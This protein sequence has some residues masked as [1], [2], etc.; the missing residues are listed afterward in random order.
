MLA[1]YLSLDQTSKLK[2]LVISVPAFLVSMV[3]CTIDF[4]VLWQY[5]SWANQTLASISLWICTLYLLKI[6]KPIYYTFLPALFMTFVVITYILYAPIGLGLNI[7][8]AKVSAFLITLI[9][10]ITFLVFKKKIAE[11]TV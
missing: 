8:I 6:K 10:A 11:K 2:R 9:I 3:L 1:E 5:F 7:D 4:Q